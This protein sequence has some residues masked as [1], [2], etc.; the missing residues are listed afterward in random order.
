MGSKLSCCKCKATPKDGSASHRRIRKSKIGSKKIRD[1]NTPS[2]L[3]QIIIRTDVP[4]LTNHHEINSSVNHN[5]QPN[6]KQSCYSLQHISERE[7]LEDVDIDP[8]TNPTT[9]PLFMKKS[10]SKSE[11]DAIYLRYNFIYCLFLF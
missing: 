1:V 10:S 7:P 11:W 8:S 9:G 2:D 4:H 6:S 3:D 5:Q